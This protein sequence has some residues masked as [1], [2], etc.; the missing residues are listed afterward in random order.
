MDDS[1]SFDQ[2]NRRYDDLHI[3]ML[4]SRFRDREFWLE[5][6]VECFAA[7]RV[8][9]SEAAP[10]KILALLCSLRADRE[11]TP[12]DMDELLLQMD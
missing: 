10:D 3:N 4:N 2:W 5:G 8:I 11:A 7:A 12:S 9:C 1:R 6:L